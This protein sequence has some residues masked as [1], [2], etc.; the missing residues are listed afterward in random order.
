[1]GSLWFNLAL[2]FQLLAAGGFIVFLIRQEK[3]VFRCSYWILVTGFL[4]HTVFLAYRYYLLGAAPILGLKSALGFFAWSI[5][6]VYLIVQSRFRLMVLGSFVAPFA[7]FL[8]IVSS[9]MPL[10]EG[11][12][13]PLFKS[14]W[15]TVHVGLIFIGDAL[16]AIAFLA[17][18]MYLIQERQIKRKRL[19]AIY[20]RLPSL[21]TLDR[22]N[23]Y[24]IVYG[25][26]FLTAG[27]ITGS[28]Y[29]QYALGNYWQWDP[30]EVWS[31]ISWLF[32]AALLHQ[33]IA[34][35]WQGRRAAVMAIVC[36]SVLVFTFV[37]VSL[38]MGGYHS[39][40][41]MGAR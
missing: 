28:V 38:L 33:R 12:V 3:W 21:A 34:V 35:G 36:F 19:G 40:G 18:V 32:Y 39:F 7:A 13:K 4:F 31:L 25:F 30:K 10:V 9:A 1:M 22:I 16:L 37:G 2:F 41:S 20:S 8:M 6:C 5:I 15:L 17:A 29:A 27:M 11:P 14:L 24:S 26:P 23:Y